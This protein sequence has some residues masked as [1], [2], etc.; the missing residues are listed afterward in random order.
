MLQKIIDKMKI[1]P[2]PDSL[3]ELEMAEAL[4]QY[5]RFE[6]KDALLLGNE[7]VRAARE[8]GEV[9]IQIL[10]LRDQLELF[11]YVGE[12]KSRRN[13]EYAR[14]KANA[15]LATGH[16]SL[17]GLLNAATTGKD[18]FGLEE[19]EDCLPVGGAFPI[20]VDGEIEALVMVS[21]LPDGL[22]HVVLVGARCGVLGCEIPPYHGILI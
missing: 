20:F 21:G 11:Q 16:C 2:D 18:A 1:A 5:E 13:L 17:W 12:G 4:F 3:H 8:R 7:I 19:R 6:G 9:A 10:R 22:D 15:A 14:A